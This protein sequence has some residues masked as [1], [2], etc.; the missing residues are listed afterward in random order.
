[1]VTVG[2]GEDNKQSPGHCDKKARKLVSIR[3]LA[4]N[5]MP[6]RCKLRTLNAFHTFRHRD[7]IKKQ[8]LQGC[9]TTGP[10]RAT[11]LQKDKTDD[12]V[13]IYIKDMK[14]EKAST[15]RRNLRGILED[16][17]HCLCVRQIQEKRVE[18]VALRHQ[19]QPIIKSLFKVGHSVVNN[20][21]IA[22]RR[23][24]SNEEQLQRRNAYCTHRALTRKQIKENL[25]RL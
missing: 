17:Q 9:I 2:R 15:L 3:N 7:S 16:D 12:L 10:A 19:K 24:G 23:E 4:A 20:Y 1:M 25:G 14:H 13:A 8:G 6:R 5:H 18:L 21:F 22:V 11:G